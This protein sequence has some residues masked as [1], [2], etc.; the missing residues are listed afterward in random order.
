M[1]ELKLDNE[2]I[3][4]LSEQFDTNERFVEQFVSFFNKNIKIEI[5]K[6][7]LSH[8]ISSIEE[9][10]NV[11]QKADFVKMLKENK[12]DKHYIDK[13][14]KAVNHKTLRLFSILLVPFNSKRN[15]QT[16]IIGFSAVILYN[17]QLDDKQKR[18]LI[19][20][21]LGHIVLKYLYDGV[22]NTEN[23]AS[24]FSF[25]SMIDKNNFYKTH[26]KDYLY[27]TDIELL[28]VIKNIC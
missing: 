25:I 3:E 28:N 11:K 16:R 8:L 20:H 5:Q 24:L 26:C 9:M 14:E 18:V 27:K 4:K 1:N 6:K 21:E 22:K 15:A 13:V 17:P 23:M 12:N 19:A 2:I 10:I 7:Y